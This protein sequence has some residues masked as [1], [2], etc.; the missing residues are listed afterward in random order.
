MPR[1]AGGGPATTLQGADARKLALP[2]T[3]TTNY[4][5]AI[6]YWPNFHRDA[7]HQSKKGE[8][9][10]E[11]EI[12]KEAKPQFAGHDQPKVPLWGYRDES[13]PQPSHRVDR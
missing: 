5:V 6:Y 13:N 8:G 3:P 10:T 12:V 9:W 11:W 1:L 7:Y 2:L 4:T